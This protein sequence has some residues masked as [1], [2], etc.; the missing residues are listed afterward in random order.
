MRNIARVVFEKK[1]EHERI[2]ESVRKCMDFFMIENDCD[3]KN[4]IF[5]VNIGVPASFQIMVV[6]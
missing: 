4:F 6:N 3:I 2:T 5:F 1:K